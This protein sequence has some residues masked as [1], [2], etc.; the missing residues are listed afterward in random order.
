MINKVRG[1]QNEHSCAI[2]VRDFFKWSGFSTMN[3]LR[4]NVDLGNEKCPASK[5]E[6]RSFSNKLRLTT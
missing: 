3:K 4:G 2:F 6:P 1:G 5:E